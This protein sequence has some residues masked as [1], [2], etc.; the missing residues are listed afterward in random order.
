MQMFFS[1]FSISISFT[2]YMKISLTDYMR[3][4]V[5]TIVSEILEGMKITFDKGVFKTEISRTS[6]KQRK[7]NM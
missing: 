2:D 7:P 3:I 6:K 1:S 5:L 4:L